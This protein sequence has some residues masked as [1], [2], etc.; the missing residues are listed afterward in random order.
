MTNEPMYMSPLEMATAYQKYAP[1]ALS[2]FNYLNG[3]INPLNVCT[4]F[5][6][7]FSV[8]NYAQFQY[9]NRMCIF[10]ASIIE[11]FYDKSKT[12]Q[13]NTDIIMSVTALCIAHELYHA[14][15]NI[16]AYKYR[17]DNSY[18]TNIENSAEY[19]AE[20]FCLDNV[21]IFKSM[22]GFKYAC[23]EDISEELLKS[24]YE[25]IKDA[26]MSSVIYNYMLGVFRCIRISDD[27]INILNSKKHKDFSI[28]IYYKDKFVSEFDVL[29][30]GKYVF[31]FNE[32][33]AA[34]SKIIVPES[35][36]SYIFD[37]RCLENTYGGVYYYM[38]NI[39][40]YTYDGIE[41]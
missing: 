1:M 2:I 19:S 24:H 29:R 40:S 4:P 7:W 32:A 11:N 34:I 41:F 17:H 28:A 27:I 15:Q 26:D 6:G 39:K 16:D 22:F 13:S 10:L 31:N 33:G 8:D 37:M 38:I 36:A 20:R 30:N 14:N 12:E 21:D 25:S 18:M 9:P 23:R 35:T 5:I 3:K